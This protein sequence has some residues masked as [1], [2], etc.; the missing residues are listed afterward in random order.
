MKKRKLEDIW[1]EH[2]NVAEKLKIRSN[3]GRSSLE[4]DQPDLM[5]TI[6]EIVIF[7]SSVDERRRTETIRSCKNLDQLH[8]Q[9]KTWVFNLVGVLHIYDFY[10]EIHLLVKG[11]DMYLQFQ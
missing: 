2:L 10:H 5:Q 4:E 1:L 3:P 6:M 8:E 9:L 7:G 11:K